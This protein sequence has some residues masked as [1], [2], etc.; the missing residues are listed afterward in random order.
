VD[1]DEVE[2][3]IRAH[4][5]A[6]LAASPTPVTQIRLRAVLD[7]LGSPSQ[8]VPIEDVPVWRTALIRLRSGPDDWRLAYG[9]CFLFVAAPLVGGAVGA[10]LFLI[11]IL[12]ARAALELL[13]EADEPVGAR[14]WLLYPP[15]V[16]IYIGLAA[17]VLLT[18]PALVASLADPTVRGEASGWFPEPFWASMLVLGGAVAGAWWMSLGLALIRWHRAVPATFRPFADWFERRHAVR[19]AYAG[20]GVVALA[21]AALILVIR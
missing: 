7:Q 3:D 6:E 15:L 20:F 13:A 17:T 1:A 5:D 9:T 12:L 19:L 4:I 10:V 14:R 11:S 16:A 2:R 8:W 21:T 18:P